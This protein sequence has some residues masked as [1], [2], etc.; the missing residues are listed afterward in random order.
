MNSCDSS[1]WVY[2][3]LATGLPIP[4]AAAVNRSGM[5]F[6]AVSAL[7]PGTAEVIELP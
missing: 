4:I 3:E 5:V 6:A 7:V 2:S 1:T